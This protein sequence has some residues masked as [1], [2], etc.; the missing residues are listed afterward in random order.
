MTK[1]VYFDH[2]AASP[3]LPEVRAEMERWLAVTG[4]PMSLHEWAR[5]PADAVEEARGDVAAL[6]GWHPDTVVFTA[7]ATE[8]RNLAVKGAMWARGAN[9][10]VLVA[11]PLAHSSTL[12][13]CRSLT[14]IAGELRLADVDAEGRVM[15]SSL[16]ALAPGADLVTI[17]HGQAEVGTVQDAVALVAAVR[18]AARGTV[19]HVDAEETAGLLPMHDGLGA[20]L[21]SIG[22]RVM[23][24]PAWV[25]ALLVRPGTPLHPLI[26]GGLE[27]NGKRGG[28][29]DVPAIAGLGLAARIA[30]REMH[31]RSARMRTCA[32]RL[33]TGL[34]ARP[35]VRLNGP[36]AAERLPGHVQVSVAGVEGEALALAL[37]A[38]DVAASPGS[39][40]TFGAGKASPVLEAM[41]RDDE[42]ARSA[43][44]LVAGPGTT[45]D[46]IDLAVRAF[47]DCVDALRRM[48]PDA[49]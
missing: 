45:D 20:D 46:E 42:A 26:E 19:V 35:G 9:P 48:S 25:G 7:G 23:G 24:A 36:P 28:A 37:A 5:G 39:A 1:G 33:A 47:A 49:P 40:C 38:R 3:L 29:H 34:L 8:A 44:L 17:T 30:Q 18:A 43:V 32:D 41:G 12:A 14:R 4:S 16:G 10:P 31:S 11:D 15:V 21:L 6:L 2:G 27:E 22:G 13:A